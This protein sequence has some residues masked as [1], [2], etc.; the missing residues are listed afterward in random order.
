LLPELGK[1]AGVRHLVDHRRPAV[2]LDARLRIFRLVSPGTVAFNELGRIETERSADPIEIDLGGQGGEL[3]RLFYGEASSAGTD[4]E[5]SHSLEAQLLKRWPRTLLTS[6]GRRLVSG[7]LSSWVDEQRGRGFARKDLP[8][9]FY[10]L[11]RLSNWAGQIGATGEYWRDAA[12]PP[13]TAGIL[14]FQFG[15]S[16]ADRARDRF[17]LDALRALRPELVGVPFAGASPTWDSTRVARLAHK[18]IDELAR[19]LRVHAPGARGGT[20]QTDDYLRLHRALGDYVQQDLDVWRVLD[21]RRALRLVRRN[22]LTL[23]P[24]ERQQ[25]YRLS[26]VFH[27]VST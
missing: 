9:A 4:A 19:R 24:R 8:D 22:P 7:Y 12:S 25:V 18:S 13:W 11:E 27:I 5:V 2:D 23:H 16:T 6:E 17:H 26:T 1:A 3:A 21:R 20:P 15:A 14:P 10:R